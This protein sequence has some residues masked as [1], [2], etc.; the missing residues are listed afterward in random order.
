MNDTSW[1][2]A[3]VAGITAVYALAS[4][5]MARSPVSSAMVFAAFGI[6]LGPVGVDLVDIQ[7]DNGPLLTALEAALALV[8]FSDAMAVPWQELRAA[9]SLPGRLLGI[10]LPV[11]IAAGWLLAWPLLPGLSGWE[12]ALVA[13]ILA[14]TDAALGSD[15]IANPGVPR[16]IRQ[17]L[18][19]ESGLNDGMV[20]PFFVLFLAGIPGTSYEGEHVAGTLWRALVL[21]PVLG[22][23]VGLAGGR[24][25]R[26]SYRAGWITREWRQVYFLALAA[27][28]YTLAVVTESSGFI[29][30]WVAGLALA[31]ALR[32][33]KPGLPEDARTALFA[34]YLGSLLAMLSLFIFGAVLLGPALEHLSWRIVG[35]AVLSLTVVRAVPVALALAGTRLKKPTIAYV[36]W[37]GPRG[38]ASIVLGLLVAEEQVRGA[39]LVGRM[40]AVTVGL[41]I[42]LHGA[43]A[44]GL[45]NRYARWYERAAGTE[46]DLQESVASPA[47]IRRRGIGAPQ[48]QGQ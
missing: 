32:A 39:E 11:S 36:A 1:T 17:T 10:G 12:L 20:L 34:E 19:V 14:P 35:Y 43:T 37:F 27:G 4:G 22:L 18:T 42:L 6:A 44:Q 33:E 13:A 8:L 16:L 30:A 41:S 26:L 24:V 46:P 29:S 45:S 47:R 25:Y 28:A 9:A 31:A 23:A 5:R 2:G 21:S 40:V 48:R 7:K 15:A 38:L 3:A